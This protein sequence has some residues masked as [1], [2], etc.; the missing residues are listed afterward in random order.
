MNFDGAS[1][2][3]P[4]KTGIGGVIRNKAGEIVHIYCRALG[5]STNNEAEFAALEQVL[6][7]LRTI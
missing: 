1:R 6:K 4:G 7:I 3:N 5:E 2:G